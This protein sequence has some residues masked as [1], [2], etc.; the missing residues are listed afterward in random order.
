M[1]VLI[2][3]GTGSLGIELKKIFPENISPTHEELDITSKKQIKKFF[4]Q[5]NIDTVIHT[6][7][8][9]KIRKCEENKQ[10]TWNVNVEGTKNLINEIIHSKIKY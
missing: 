10:L 4:Q 5:N 2:T 7:A 9:T 8:I 3:G 1:T 6:A